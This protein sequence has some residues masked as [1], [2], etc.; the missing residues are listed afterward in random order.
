MRLWLYEHRALV[1]GIYAGLMF[2]VILVLQALESSGM[3]R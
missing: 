3:I 2:T 1:K